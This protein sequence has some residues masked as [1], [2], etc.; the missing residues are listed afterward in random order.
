MKKNLFALLKAL[1]ITMG[2]HIFLTVAIELLART[3]HKE[4]GQAALF[5]TVTLF[6]VTAIC[7]FAAI[8][9]DK[10][11]ILWGCFGIGISFGLVLS[12]VSMIFYSRTLREFW[13][14]EGNLAWLLFLLLILT[15]WSV[16]VFWVT[17]FRSNRIGRESR[18]SNR[19]VKRMRKGF[20][21]EFPPVSKG[22]ARVYAI[23]KGFL[24]VTWYHTLTGLLLF[25]LMG[26]GIENT[27]VS[28]VSFPVLW[29]L[30]AAL[31]GGLDRPCRGDFALSAALSNLVFFV[32][33]SY[34]CMLVY[35]EP[36]QYRFILHL[37]GVLTSPF[38]NPEQLL[39]IAIFFSVWIAMAVFAVGHRK[40]KTAETERK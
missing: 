13:P 36:H 20:R 1:F 35:T 7:L 31:Y 14:G 22:R 10:R 26:A 40:R 4:L 24:W 23:V 8:P 34:F 27:M 38:D 16:G 2:L 5:L 12:I 15:S 6:L 3:V 29:C 28:Y 39:A 17:V 25:L 18:E 37:D 33:S 32:L 19:Q 21:R 30:M 11:G 9:T